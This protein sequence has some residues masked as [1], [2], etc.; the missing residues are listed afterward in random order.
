MR[1]DRFGVDPGLNRIA[2]WRGRPLRIEAQLAQGPALREPQLQ[3]HQIDAGDLLG[4]RVLDLQAWVGLDEDEGRVCAI[5]DGPVARFGFLHQKFERAQAP[6]AGS[7][8]ERTGRLDD[9]FAQR[10]VQRRAGRD[11]DQLLE[12]P[13][14]RAVAL[15]QRDHVGPI[16]GDLH[17][18]MARPHN[19]PFG[20]DRVDAER[21]ARLRTAARIGLGQRVAFAHHAHAP[22]AAPADRLQHDAG[23]LLLVEEGRHC[24]QRR[25]AFGG[26]HHRHA[27]LARQRQRAALVAEQCELADRRADEDQVGLGAG[28]CEVGA[29][30]EKSVAGM[31]RVATGAA[32]GGEDGRD[33]E[34][35][36][37]AFAVE[38]DRFVGQQAVAA[39]GI[40][41]CVDG[42]GRDA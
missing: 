23:A 18:D 33:V 11:L 20:I 17:F 37:G 6:V 8:R 7:A 9:A 12:A 29:F 13:L 27:A 39:I 16:A 41:A 22:A 3:R 14:Q 1:I 19:Q 4:D 30:A 5:A 24:L 38:R 26:W 10:G 28:L 15:A 2:A 36:G 35:G 25:A 21:R 42:D 31:D 40:V 34:V 32:R